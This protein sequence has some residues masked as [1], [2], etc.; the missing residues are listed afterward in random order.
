MFYNKTNTT[1][2]NKTNTT[3]TKDVVDITS[4]A[5]GSSQLKIRFSLVSNGSVVNDGIYIDNIKILN[6][7]AVP[8]NITTVSSETPDKYVLNQ[9]YPNP[10][11][12]ST[13]ISFALPERNFVTLKIY[14]VLGK[15]VVTLVNEVKNAGTYK[16]DF[17]ASGLSSGIYYYT[18][19][20]GN[21]FQTKKMTLIK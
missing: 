1:W 5:N 18:I 6:Y 3:W 17:N 12:P 20:S 4:L 10:F 21:F 14:D 13:Q 2:Y 7:N 8:T 9:N 11:N 15:E 16:Y 19:S